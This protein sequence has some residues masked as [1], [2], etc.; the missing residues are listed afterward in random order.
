MT[1][2]DV[3]PVA[4]KRLYALVFIEH[5]TRRLHLAGGT[6]HPTAQWTVQQARN[7]AM[8]SG[9]LMDSVRFHATRPVERTDT[10]SRSRRNLGCRHPTVDRQRGAID[11]SALGPG[12]E[13]NERGDLLRSAE[14]AV[15]LSCRHRLAG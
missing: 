2:T 6:A 4:L 8:T 14:P 3:F 10:C 1:S 13:G 15:E 11:E 12:N 7:L 5:G 9:C